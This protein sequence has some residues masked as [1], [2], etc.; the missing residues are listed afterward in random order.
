MG[1]GKFKDLRVQ[2]MSMF[3]TPDTGAVLARLLQLIETD[4]LEPVVHRTYDLAETA[5]AHR[6]VLDESFL[7]KL[8]V[9]P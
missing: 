7:G 6:A 5:D 3:N 4:R 1:P 2:L 8:V 9:E